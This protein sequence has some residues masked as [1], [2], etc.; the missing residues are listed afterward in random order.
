MDEKA[1]WIA[2]IT[3]LVLDGVIPQS[4]YPALRK[5]I[6]S[7]PVA[8][9]AKERVTEKL[10]GSDYVHPGPRPNHTLQQPL[11]SP[12][13]FRYMNTNIKNRYVFVSSRQHHLYCC[14]F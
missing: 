1:C 5:K 3:Q 10:P 2:E 14:S 7:L 9:T 6:E 8:S 12:M 11:Y 13:Q 4:V